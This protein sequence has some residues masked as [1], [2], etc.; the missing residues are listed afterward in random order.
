MEFIENL[1]ISIGP[2]L[3]LLGTYLLILAHQ[4]S[5]EIAHTLSKGQVAEG[6]VIE[7]RD[8]SGNTVESFNNHPVAPVVEFKTDHGKY[9]HYSRTFQNPSPYKPGQSVKIYYYIYKSIQQFALEDDQTGTLPIR[10][11][12][13]GIVFCAVGFPGLVIKLSRL[14]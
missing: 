5:N 11:Y 6:I 12:R 14:L 8:E 3:V 13:W 4:K 9:L 7:M 10:L 2:I 1:L